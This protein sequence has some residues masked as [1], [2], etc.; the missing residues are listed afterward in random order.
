MTVPDSGSRA[1][2]TGY[3]TGLMPPHVAFV[4]AF[5]DV[6]LNTLFPEEAQVVAHAVESRRREFATVRSCARIAMGRL[7]FAPAP[8][9]PGLRGA[10][11]WPDGLI[12]T[13]THCTGYRAAAV[14]RATELLGIGMDAERNEP[15]PNPGILRHIARP[16]EQE[17]LALLASEHPGVCWDRLLFSAKE[18]V[19]KTW[20]PLARAFLDFMECRVTLHPGTGTFSAQLLVPGPV[21]EG[22]RLSGFTGHWAVRGGLILTAI[23]LTPSVSAG[24]RA[25]G[26]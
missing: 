25:G 21:V 14:G 8:L 19:Y 16:E 2:G 3:K 4:E 6:P 26:A 9:L 22:V 7:G 15:L 10:P 12:G 1:P 5:D 20:F 23:A 17:Q 24:D 13:M 11:G 18:S